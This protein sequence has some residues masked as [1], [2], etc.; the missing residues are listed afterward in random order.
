MMAE[1]LIKFAQT[2]SYVLE[3][4]E[5]GN[6]ANQLLITQG[7][8]RQPADSNPS[9]GNGIIQVVVWQTGKAQFSPVL[10]SSG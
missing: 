4:M 10:A 1:D 5:Y 3:A 2:T 6:A 8:H 7:A 9:T